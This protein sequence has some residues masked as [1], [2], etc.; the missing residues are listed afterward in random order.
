MD[1]LDL[2]VLAIIEWCDINTY[3]PKYDKY[4][5]EDCSEEIANCAIDNKGKVVG[6]SQLRICSE[7]GR[8]LLKKIDP[9]SRLLVNN[10]KNRS[11]K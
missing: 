5:I 1:G 8:L 11:N 7:Q 3:P 9:K 4:S 6:E 10:S 2:L